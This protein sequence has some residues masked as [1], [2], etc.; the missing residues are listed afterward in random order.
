MISR[1]GCVSSLRAGERDDS[2]DLVCPA[3][4]PDRPCSRDAPSSGLGLKPLQSEQVSYAEGFHTLVA[5]D[6]AAFSSNL[7]ADALTAE[8]RIPSDIARA[9]S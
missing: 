7:R 5:A 6:Q 2:H 4:M 1:L 3:L 9:L 8:F